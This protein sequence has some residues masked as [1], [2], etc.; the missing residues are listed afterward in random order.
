MPSEPAH[1]IVVLAPGEFAFGDADTLL[2]TLLGSCIALTFWHPHFRVGAMCHY[3]LPFR[4]SHKL[5]EPSGRYAD[6]A[7][8]AI[9]TRFRNMGLAAPGFE[10]RM[11]G[12]ANMFPGLT[13]ET[14]SI[15]D[16]N[17]DAGKELMGE[18]GYRI[19]QE[20]LGGPLHRRV[21]FSVG[22][23]RVDVQYGEGPAR[24]RGGRR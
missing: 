22:S 3:M 6:E 4:P 8:T 15:G 21:V 24:D 7:L 17:I 5:V 10:V 23:G 11:F 1:R 12:G 14:P 20:D 2:Q 18:L 9:H 19:L 13:G 16:R